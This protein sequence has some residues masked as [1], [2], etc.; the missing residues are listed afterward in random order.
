MFLQITGE[1]FGNG[2]RAAAGLPR[3]CHRAPD[4]SFR[5]HASRPTRLELAA[6]KRGAMFNANVCHNRLRRFAKASYA[7]EMRFSRLPG[8]I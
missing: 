2:Q 5:L 4:A 7:P 1:F 8:T 6:D 3:N